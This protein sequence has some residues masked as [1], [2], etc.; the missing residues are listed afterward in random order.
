MEIPAGIEIKK[1]PSGG[2][3]LF[4]NMFAWIGFFFNLSSSVLVFFTTSLIIK[5]QM[6]SLQDV[7]FMCLEQ[8]NQFQEDKKDMCFCVIL[9]VS[10]FANSL[11]LF[12]GG[13]A[14]SAKA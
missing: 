9:L 6:T 14:D 8:Q 4:S 3:G 13:K 12:Y 2:D 7:I 1:L 11:H 10:D 5:I